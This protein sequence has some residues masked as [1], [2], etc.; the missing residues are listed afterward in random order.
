M[1]ALNQIKLLLDLTKEIRILNPKFVLLHNNSV[2]LSFDI[3]TEVFPVSLS[4]AI[5]FN[6]KDADKTR[7]FNFSIGSSF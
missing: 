5:P 3:M 1:I 6:K 2:G 4:Y 7:E